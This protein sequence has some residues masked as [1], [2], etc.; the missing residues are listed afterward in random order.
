MLKSSVV[1]DPNQEELAISR[2]IKNL[3][4]TERDH[5]N[6]VLG[7]P[8]AVRLEHIIEKDRRICVMLYIA[9]SDGRKYVL[10]QGMVFPRMEEVSIQTEK[11]CIYLDANNY[12]LNLFVNNK[13]YE[14]R[15]F[16]LAK[17]GFSTLA[18][19]TQ[20]L[21]ISIDCKVRR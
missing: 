9:F 12:L 17:E 4:F 19:S 11:D 3:D 5:H 7:K 20:V 13:G 1:R 15:I 8:A 10:D 16:L 6:K 21:D 18:T 14:F 2:F